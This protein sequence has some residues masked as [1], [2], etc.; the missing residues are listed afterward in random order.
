MERASRARQASHP[1]VALRA[2][3]GIYGRLFEHAQLNDAT[4]ERLGDYLGHIRYKTYQQTIYYATMRRLTDKAGSNLVTYQ[5]I[6]QRMNFPICFLHGMKNEVFDKRTS[7]RSFDLLASIFWPA[8]LK[9]LWRKNPERRYKYSLYRKGRSLRIVE[10][11]NFGHQDCMIGRRA[12][13]KVYPQISAFLEQCLPFAR[14]N[15]LTALVVVRPPKLGPDR[16]LAARV[17]GQA[18]LGSARPVHAE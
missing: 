3:H 9:K 10:V 16:W 17:G 6:R 12:H 14:K 2:C 4:L 15:W 8:D 13:K 1:R 7:E 11:H 18:E 5:N